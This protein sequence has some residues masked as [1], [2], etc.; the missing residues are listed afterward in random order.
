VFERK[1]RAYDEFSGLIHDMAA[2]DLRVGLKLYAFMFD[3]VMV[4]WKGRS[5]LPFSSN[6]EVRLGLCR[7]WVECTAAVASIPIEMSQI[8]I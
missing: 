6:G 1:A 5:P 8:C 7:G 4:R 3:L 2:H